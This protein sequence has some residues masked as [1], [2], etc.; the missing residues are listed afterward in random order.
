MLSG[1]RLTC[2]DYTT[3]SKRGRRLNLEFL[4]DSNDNDFDYICMDSTGIQTYTGNE[5]RHYG[6]NRF[7]QQSRLVH[8][9]L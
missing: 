3:L 1:S 7:M 6:Q 9:L 5:W 2:P 4:L 8:I